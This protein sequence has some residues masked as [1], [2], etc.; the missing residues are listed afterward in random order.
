[1]ICRGRLVTTLL[2]GTGRSF[3]QQIEWNGRDQLNDLVPLGTY[4]LHYE[5]VNNTTGKKWQKAA[6]IVIGTV[7]K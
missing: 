2:D 6:P 3:E 5:V 4:I 1:M 7:L